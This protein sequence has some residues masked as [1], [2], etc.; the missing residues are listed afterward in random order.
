M[1]PL[2]QSPYGERGSVRRADPACTATARGAEELR[3][4]PRARSRGREARGE[5][6][7]A[8]SRGLREPDAL[9]EDPRGAAPEPPVHPRPIRGPWRRIRGRGGGAG[10]CGG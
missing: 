10:P 1:R 7:E 8:L 6:Q 9:A 5:A 2:L 4:E 3:G